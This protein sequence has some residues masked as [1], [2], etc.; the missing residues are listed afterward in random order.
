MR[1]CICGNSKPRETKEDAAPVASIFSSLSM[2]KYLKLFFHYKYLVRKNVV[3]MTGF[4]PATSRPPDVH[5]NRAELHPE[6]S[7]IPNQTGLRN[8]HRYKRMSANL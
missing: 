3:G 8:E 4:E 5:S 7:F 1:C 6:I 2:D